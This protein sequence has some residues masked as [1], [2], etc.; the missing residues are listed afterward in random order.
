MTNKSNSTL[1]TI[2]VIAILLFVSAIIWKTTRID[3]SET[4]NIQPVATQN[5]AKKPKKI[6]KEDTF[7]V[8]R[9][10][11]TIQEK[12]QRIVSRGKE[13]GLHIKYNSPEKLMEAITKL[14]ELGQEEEANYYIDFLLKKY[15]DYQM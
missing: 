6:A 15:P 12:E 9:I 11:L 3:N 2:I 4:V 10:E 1:V 7:D 14:Q 5:N 8:E 13:M